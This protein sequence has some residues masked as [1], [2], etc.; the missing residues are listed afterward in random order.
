MAA[1]IVPIGVVVYEIT[2]LQ[3]DG[4]RPQR[5]GQADG[6]VGVALLL[7]VPGPPIGK[8]GDHRRNALLLAQ[9]NKFLQ[10]PKALGP[11]I[12][13]VGGIHH[14]R[15]LQRVHPDAAFAS[16]FRGDLG[17]PKAPLQH[18]RIQVLPPV[19]EHVQGEQ[20]LCPVLWAIV[21]VPDGPQLGHGQG[22]GIHG[23]VGHGQVRLH[24]VGFGEKHIHDGYLGLLV[25][26]SRF[27][28]PV[29]AGNGA[30][31]DGQIVGG[32]PVVTPQLHGKHAVHH[33]AGAEKQHIVLPVVPDKGRIFVVA[34]VH[35]QGIG[36]EGHPGQN[37]G[38][39]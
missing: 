30:S 19:V 7:S 16:L 37:Q 3:V 25:V 12:G 15:L 11:L 9:Q 10:I 20:E 33:M 38:Q 36:P 32:D 35:P 14:Q 26:Q 34:V 1:V 18:F 31:V 8:V 2:V 24:I 4:L 13:N 6:G 39:Q 27:Q 17:F 5:L 22:E 28:H 23:G 29:A 21:D